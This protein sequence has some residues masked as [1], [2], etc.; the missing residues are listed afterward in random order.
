MQTVILN[1]LLKVPILC[2]NSIKKKLL[3]GV[4]WLVI[5]KFIQARN[6]PE[7]ELQLKKISI[8]L[9]ISRAFS[10]SIFDM[11]GAQLTEDSAIPGQV[12]LGG[13]RE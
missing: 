7:E 1:M 11:E 4:S 3:Q 13:I 2:E 8:R 9:P 12:I 6:I 5:V 10:W